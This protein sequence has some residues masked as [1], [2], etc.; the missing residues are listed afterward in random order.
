MKSLESNE[1]GAEFLDKT[2]QFNNDEQVIKELANLTPFEYDRVRNEKATE[3]GVQTATL[4]KAVK[5]A[6]KD[7]QADSYN[8]KTPEPW[9]EEVNGSDVLNS[10]VNI[11]NDYLVLPEGASE[12]LSL[13]VAYTHAFD[14]FVH[15][16]RLNSTS[17]E[18]EC[19][20][21]LS[22]RNNGKEIDLLGLL[23][24]HNAFRMDKSVT[25]CGFEAS[26]FGY[27]LANLIYACAVRSENVKLSFN[28][29]IHCP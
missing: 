1:R 12:I 4:D 7:L 5:A 13:W 22:R 16:P 27:S 3:L 6:R 23:N 2:Q 9:H 10:V 20:K 8:L 14:A 17:P 28:Q 24:R 21:A 25:R 18:K 29:V 19:G 11:F 26:S 15:S